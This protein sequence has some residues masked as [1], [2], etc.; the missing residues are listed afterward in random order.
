MFKAEASVEHL[1]ASANGGGNNDE[2]CVACCKAVNALLHGWFWQTE[3]SSP[4]LFPARPGVSRVIYLRQVL[5]VQV[6]IDLG[7][8][9]V[10]VAKHLL[11]R[12]EIT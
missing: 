6:G 11:D 10:G 4:A 2:N 9:D 8:G 7:G 3:E 5:P 1:R 12:P